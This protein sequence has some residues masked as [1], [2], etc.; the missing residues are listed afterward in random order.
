[1]KYG[2]TCNVHKWEDQVELK[3]DTYIIVSC[4]FFSWFHGTLQ[5]NQNNN[6]EFNDSCSTQKQPNSSRFMHFC[7][8]YLNPSSS[9]Q[10]MDMWFY[11]VT[12]ERH[13]R[14]PSFVT[15]ISHIAECHH[16]FR[17]HFI[18]HSTNMQIF[19]VYNK[20]KQPITFLDTWSF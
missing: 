5:L 8:F 14:S 18:E 1:L 11:R 10:V 13:I 9:C 16:V 12:L 15:R 20:Q 7:V 3:H 4:T 17:V 6:M 19:W 2:L